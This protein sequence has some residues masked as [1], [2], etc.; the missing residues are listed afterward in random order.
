MSYFLEL[1][2]TFS[3]TVDA[4]AYTDAWYSDVTARIP[5]TAP[6]IE[7]GAV[8]LLF[9]WSGNMYDTPLDSLTSTNDGLVYIFVGTILLHEPIPLIIIGSVAGL[10]GLGYIVLE[11]IPSIEPPEN[12]RDASAESWGAE[13][14]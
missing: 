14:I 8:P 6:A 4:R 11:Y 2:S 7:M 12:M 3:N 13:Q 1:V 5:D 9:P 10:A